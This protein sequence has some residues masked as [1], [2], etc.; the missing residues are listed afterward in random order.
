[1]KDLF[2]NWGKLMAIQQ[3][4]LTV[5]DVQ[6]IMLAILKDVI[7]YF[8]KHDYHYVLTGGSAL[9]A[10]RHQGFIPWDDDADVA[11]PRHEY[12][13]FIREYK[14]NSTRYEILT[15]LNTEN[16][17]YG[18]ARVSDTYTQADGKWATVSNGVYVDVFPIDAVP[19]SGI[20]QKFAYYHMKYLDVMRNSTRRLAI[21]HKEP[22]WW[23]KP[24]LI[25]YAKRHTTA[26]WV[27]KMNR[28]AQ[29][30]NQRYE[31]KS[32]V[33]SLYIVQGLN[34]TRENFP[35]AIYRQRQL[36]KFEDLNVYIP[37]ANQHYLSQMYGDWQA[38]PS[39]SKRKTHARFYYKGVEV[40]D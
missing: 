14:P 40:H 29:K 26:W 25:K 38:L 22:A 10:V 20:G 5:P 11:L 31:N 33:Y 28:L 19:S 7:T 16:W 30:T 37:A 24:L 23:L 8:D 6:R 21:S 34:K 27:N 12:E 13:R 3:N 36:V 2:R 17:L 9:G 35:L 4:Y 1:M 15:P 39:K 18:Y 32:D